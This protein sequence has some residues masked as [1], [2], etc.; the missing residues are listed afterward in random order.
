MIQV[1]CSQAVCSSNDLNLFSNTFQWMTHLVCSLRTRSSKSICFFLQFQVVV[2]SFRL[3]F[4]LSV[5][6]S[7]Q[8]FH[9]FVCS[10]FDLLTQFSFRVSNFRC[11]SSIKW[12]KVIFKSTKIFFKFGKNIFSFL[13]KSQIHKSDGSNSTKLWSTMKCTENKIESWTRQSR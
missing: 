3:T 8:C 13:F 12:L 1:W 6:S 5:N 2:L 10:I 9:Y 4:F 11:N 7:V